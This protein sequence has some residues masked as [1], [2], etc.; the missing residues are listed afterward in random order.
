MTSSLKELACFNRIDAI[1]PINSGLSSQCYQ[2][3]ADD[4]VFFAKKITTKNESIASTLAAKKYFSPRVILH[5]PQWLITEYI[6]SENLSLSPLPVDKKISISMEL[7]AQCHQLNVKVD[8]LEPDF[9]T[10]DLIDKPSYSIQEQEE[11]IIQAKGVLPPLNLTKNLVCCHGDLNFSNVIIDQKNKAWLVDYECICIAPV[12]YDLAMF[13]A[14]NH[15]SQSKINSIISHYEKLS[16]L[17]IVNT[18]LLNS[19]IIFSHFI[20]A[21]WY[22]NAQQNNGGSKLFSMEQQHWKKLSYLSTN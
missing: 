2:V 9:I 19:F 15:I 12:E 21:L 5:T 17:V 4:K 7:M 11:L 3:N 10:R 22:K 14:V 16:P 8:K 13:I 20:N 18:Q 1:K 6:E